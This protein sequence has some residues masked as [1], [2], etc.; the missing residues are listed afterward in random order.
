VKRVAQAGAV[1]LVAALLVLLV[2]RVATDDGGVAKKLK[3][4]GRPVT[5]P[6]FTLP[7]LDGKG[8]ISL[9]S[10][11]GKPVVINF[12]ASW[13]IPCKEEAPLFERAWREHRDKGLVVLGVDAEDFRGDARRFV[14]RY[15]LTYPIVFDRSKNVIGDFG[16]TGYPETFF[17]SPQGDVVAH[18]AGQVREAELERG[19]ALALEE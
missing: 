11:R 1:G 12:W 10:L 15:R 13:C 16:L 6:A 9:A 8:E 14:R 2:W 18:A 7:R 5:A 3:E 19:I 4:S 17:L